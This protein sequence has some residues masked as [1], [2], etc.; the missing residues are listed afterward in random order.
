MTIG[1]LTMLRMHT[2]RSIQLRFK[3]MNGKR[4]WTDSSQKRKLKLEINM[5]QLQ[6]QLPDTQTLM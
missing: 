6:L 5:E 4:T 2:N 1:W 3:H